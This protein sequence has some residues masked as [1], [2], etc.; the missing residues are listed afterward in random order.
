M[1]LKRLEMYGYKSFASRA[2]FE[3]GDGITAIVG[4]N[5][6]GKSNIADGVRWVLGEQ[7]YSNLRGRRTE[8]MIFAGSRRR[9][10]LGMA[11]VTITLDNSDRWLDIDFTEVTIGRRAYR[12]GENEYLLNGTRVRYREI[13]DLLG[14]AGLAAS[15]YI[16]IGQGMVDAAL[17]LTPEARRSLFEEAAGIAPQL[18]KREE[19]LTRIAETQRNLERAEDIINELRPRARTLRRQAERAEEH[20][21]LVQDLRELQRIWYGYQWQNVQHRVAQA[22]MQLLN[23]REHLEAQRS[24]ARELQTSQETLREQISQQ[25][26]LHNALSERLATLRNE[27]DGISRDLAIAGERARLYTQQI[28]SAA[29][30]QQA[31]LSRRSVL[32]EE[33]SRARE[34]LAEHHARH[35]TCLAE[36][37]ELK[38]AVAA[39]DQEREA[40]ARDL[41]SLEQEVASREREL[42]QRQA[43]SEQLAERKRELESERET[44]RQRSART[45]ERLE[46]MRAQAADLEARE[47]ALDAE[48][49]A[50]EQ[51]QE[52]AESE[53]L[54]SREALVSLERQ[55]SEARGDRDQILGRQR[56]LQRLREQMSDYHPGVREILRAA[57]AL[58]GIRGT[59]ASLM[60]VP[61]EYEQA[62][63]SALGSR[64][65]N[66]VTE[67]WEDAEAAI[68]LLKQR[69]AGWATFLPLDSLHVRPA[70]RPRTMTGV[71]GVASELVRYD[72]E[73]QPVFDLLLGHVLIVQDLPAARRL[74]RERTGASLLVTLE[75][76][77]VQPSGAVSGGT[78]QTQTRLLQQER[79]WRELPARLQSAEDV[80]A[81]ATNS[82]AAAQDRIGEIQASLRQRTQEIT[83]GR[84]D[85]ERAHQAQLKHGDEL[86]RAERDY[87]WLA[88][89][90]TQIGDDLEQLS[91][92][93]E[94]VSFAI[95]TLSE[96]GEALATQLRELAKRR[97]AIQDTSERQ[98]LNALETEAEVS[99]RTARSVTALLDSHIRNLEQIDQ[100][101]ATREA[102]RKEQA[103]RLQEL[104][105]QLAQ[106]Q[107]RLAALE[108]RAEETQG[109]LAP[110]HAKRVELEREEQRTIRQHADSLERLHEAETEYNQTVLERDRA[111]DRQASL[112]GEIEESLGPIDLPDV[113]A[114]QLRLN[115]DD[116]VVELPR[117]TSLP[118]GLNDEIRQLRARL[119]RVGSINPEAPREYERLLERQT[120]LQG[121]VSDL[122]GAIASLHE[123]IEELDQ[124]IEHDFGAAVKRV[125]QGFANYFEELF[126]GGSARLVLTDPDNMATTG[127]D[128]IA[129]PPGKHAQR[130]SLL[131]G[132]ERALT[133][134]A[135]LFAL[136]NANPVPFCIL[137]EVDAALDE[138]NVGRFRDMLRS[139][140]SNAQY[141]VITHNRRTIEAAETIYGISMEDQGVSQ[142][143]SLQVGQAIAGTA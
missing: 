107:E 84:R 66:L 47:Q 60:R 35:K 123:V 3:F 99:A 55:A 4:P 59:V 12:S 93:Q 7:S 121:Q 128:I 20:M 109:Q 116:N 57:D 91:Q 125:D 2:V 42:A 122:R 106:R 90:S 62:I 48:Q 142:S 41:R 112:S 29:S 104:N 75:G 111:R 13:S 100:Q 77:T 86:V 18:R 130:L 94:A 70:L 103:A 64:L 19:T 32:D 78:R 9:S 92:R 61:Q 23:A 115:L 114:H 124:V 72:S 120:F 65:E 21:L 53:L 117:V 129:H 97:D 14:A 131:S 101:I 137:D 82:V 113:T 44:V 31:L 26:T 52:E 5:G 11:E 85:R 16:V 40:I 95:A 135:L 89:R 1:R 27:A 46:T 17:A 136:L 134:V 126:G 10:R 88:S 67:R 102:Q 105:S 24:F 69:Q 58:K 51:L 49:R 8:D 36:I 15:N 37:E 80:L 76:E 34:Q 74:L 63:Q 73:L 50:L 71:V 30:D 127:V 140:A 43:Q 39:I 22:E 118:A 68:A 96:Q 133:A 108:S 98:R 139:Q 38:S 138:S 143:I 54:A 87:N 81:E 25:V 79:E 141:V 83:Q 56:S 132:G 33:V 110:V 28:A 45:A 119:R 6:S